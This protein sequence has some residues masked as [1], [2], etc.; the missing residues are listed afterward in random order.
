MQEAYYRRLAEMTPRE[1]LEIGISLCKTANAIQRAA[2]RRDF[3]GADEAE[4]TYR[5]AVSRFGEES[6]RKAYRR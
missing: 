2:L 4:I 5:I 6:A 1:R 3:P